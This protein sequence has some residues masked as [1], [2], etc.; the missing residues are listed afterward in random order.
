DAAREIANALLSGE[1]KA[2]LL[3]N[4]AAHHPQATALL[5]LATWIGEQTGAT[6]GYLTEAVNT[7]GAQLVN[8]MPR[9][10]GL[11]AGRMLS[12]PLKAYLLLNLEPALDTANPIA[13]MRA[14]QSAEMVVVMTPFK[15]VALDVA[16]VLLPVS[17]F[18]ETA[19][20]FVNAEGRVQSFHGVV[21]PLG[22]TRPGWKVLRVLG[23]ML[24]LD[25]FAQESAEEVRAEALGSVDSI[26]SRLSNR[27]AAMP[28]DSILPA[29]DLERIADVPIYHADS[30]VR[31]SPPLQQTTDAKA[32]PWA[33]ISQALWD[34]LGLQPG[35]QVRV[36]QGEGSALLPARLEPSLASN[37]VRVSVGHPTTATLGAM[38]GAIRV[39]KA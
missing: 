25:G 35:A 9:N 28:S 32:A 4:A 27:G 16:D 23:N 3:G 13:T 19:G 6:V 2:I 17:P 8:A 1:R 26:A 12:D 10:G 7:V 30:L 31:R 38:F 11:N 33:G 18:T 14:L 21:K 29:Q 5:A 37:A 24:G 20:A 15:D 34:E 39:E 22:E 36:T